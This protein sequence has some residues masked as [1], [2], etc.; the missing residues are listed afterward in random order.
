MI[1]GLEVGML[2]TLKWILGA[3]LLVVAVVIGIIIGVASFFAL[4]FVVVHPAVL[5]IVAVLL[6]GFIV[7]GLAYLL[8]R[9]FARNHRRRLAVFLGVFT[10]VVLAAAGVGFLARPRAFDEPVPVDPTGI[11]YESL[12]TGS[13][14]ACR[15]VSARGVTRQGAV[16]FV[17]GGPGADAV[18]NDTFV[19]ALS[20][21]ADAGYDVC[22]YDQIG[23]GLSSRLADPLDYTAARQVADLEALR[24]RLAWERPILIGESWGAQLIA[25]YAAGYP[26]RISAA[27]LVSP[28]P[29]R[30]ADWTDRETG[31]AGDRLTD[32]EEQAFNAVLDARFITAM[33]LLRIN[34]RAAVRFLPE[35]EAEGYGSA[36][37]TT[38]AP[39]AVCDPSVLSIGS[40][41]SFNLWVAQLTGLSMKNESSDHLDGLRATDFPVMILRGDCDYAHEDIA[42]D[43]VEAF[44]RARLVAVAD[45]GHFLLLEQPQA[46]L[47]EVGVFL[48]ELNDGL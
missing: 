46:F 8:G 33:L 13:R 26:Q 40:R 14:L 44:P 9:W 15:I 41:P 45:A 12:A 3:I 2:A 48:A 36:L 35:A 38:L 4:A 21:L 18:T 17:H 22:L 34:P 39:G 11:R 25:R 6:G 7:F 31:S 1:Y 27:V 24:E 32:G 43:Y 28:G 16:I 23:C 30:L 5:G 19:E 10:S 42:A 37:L 29:L 47:T 20:P